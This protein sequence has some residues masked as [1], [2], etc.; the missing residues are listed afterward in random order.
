M[1]IPFLSE[2]DMKHPMNEI[3]IIYTLTT[4]SSDIIIYRN[5]ASQHTVYL[6][7]AVP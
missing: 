7:I 3:I 2:K 4:Q 6:F 1:N 5:E